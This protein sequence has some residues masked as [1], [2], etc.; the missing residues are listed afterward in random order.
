MIYQFKKLTGDEQQQLL[1]APILLSVLASCS[2]N[3]IN[4]VQKAAAI[5]LAHIKTFTA[6]EELIPYYLEVEKIFKDQFDVIAEKYYPFNQEKR[7]ELKREIKKTQDILE[8]LE[9]GFSGPL[10]KSLERYA[11]HVKR[12]THSVF[13]DI[14]FPIIYFRMNDDKNI[15]KKNF[16]AAKK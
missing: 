6:M 2:E 12:A 14:I 7:A 4:K 11:S 13:Q 3:E 16:L 15:L 5:K 9:P 8:K 10:S 1:K